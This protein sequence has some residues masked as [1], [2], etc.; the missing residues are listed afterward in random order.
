MQLEETSYG[1]RIAP[2]LQ[3]R[4]EDMLIFGL[5]GMV[6]LCAALVVARKTPSDHFTFSVMALATPLIL[7]AGLWYVNRWREMEVHVQT[8]TLIYRH[9]LFGK[10]WVSE[11]SLPFTQVK[12]VS[13]SRREGGDLETT[14]D[15][16]RLQIIAADGSIWAWLDFVQGMYPAQ[17]ARQRLLEIIERVA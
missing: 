16:G 9:C 5:L 14:W 10:W 12:T 4:L 13:V 6:T 17:K 8:R 15:Y 7:L 2:A 3:K 11:K 1:L